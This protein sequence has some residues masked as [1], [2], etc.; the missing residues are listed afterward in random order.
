MAR[1]PCQPRTKTAPHIHTPPQRSPGVEGGSWESQ[2][3][4]PEATFQYQEQLTE[5]AF[6]PLHLF[7]PPTSLQEAFTRW[8]WR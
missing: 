1:L 3:L 7:F 4:V 5:V 8:S 6:V 2:S